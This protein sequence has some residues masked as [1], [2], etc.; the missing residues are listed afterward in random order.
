MSI[1]GGISNS[2]LEA[3]KS[4]FRTFQLFTASSRS[5]KQNRPD[6]DDAALFSNYLKQYDTIPFAHIPYLCNLASP[7]RDVFNKSIKMLQANID[8]CN[9]LDIGYL[10]LHLGSHLGKGFGFGSHSIIKGIDSVS[11]SLGKLTLLLEN[12]SGYTNNVGAKFSEIAVVVNGVETKNI[13]ICLDTCHAFAAGYDI[14]DKGSLKAMVDEIEDSIGMDKLKLV[15]LNDS[16]FDLGSTKDRHWHIGKGFIGE[17]GFENF[18][19]EKRFRQG[20]FVMETPVNEDGDDFSNKEALVKIM[21][22]CGI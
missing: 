14:R 21:K 22:K 15:H 4:G 12:T 2:A 17:K 10:V 1:S 7:N 16:K 13:G 6:K 8:N 3:G 5:W 9:E 11:G 20:C 18:F 19:S